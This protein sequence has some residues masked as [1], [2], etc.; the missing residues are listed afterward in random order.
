MVFFT[1]YFINELIGW[2]WM[3]S[4]LDHDQNQVTFQGMQHSRNTA[5]RLSS[6]VALV[7]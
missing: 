1:R 5:F 4:D 6:L 3:V 2:V 7:S